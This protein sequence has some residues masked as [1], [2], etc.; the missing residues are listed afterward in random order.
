VFPAGK[1]PIAS[2]PRKVKSRYRSHFVAAHRHR[3]RKEVSDPSWM[4]GP[5]D[6]LLLATDLSARCD[7]ALDRA[8]QLA[9]VWRAELLALNVLEP[10]QAPDQLL[11]WAAGDS[12]EELLGIARQQ[13]QRDLAGLEVPTRVHIGRGDVADTI[14]EVATSAGCGLVVTGMARTETFGRFLLGSTVERLSRRLSQP[15]LVVRQRPRAAY[16]RIAVAIDFSESSR[17]ALHAAARFFPGGELVVYHAYTVPMTKVAA[18]PADGRGVRKFEREL[19]AFVATSAIA[20]DVRA[21]LRLVVEQGALE[22]SLTRYVRDHDVELV[23][24]GTHG[25]SGVMSIA[26]GSVATRLLDWL[27]CDT[28]VVREPRAVR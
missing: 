16:R 27:P 11:A 15:L 2:V 26:L 25:R 6:R 5:P 14:A 7:R 13:L 21:R 23:V 19:A 24:T 9:G 8:A 4:A 12:D 3:I 10:P 18:R 20:D 28:L 1:W 17:H 22:A